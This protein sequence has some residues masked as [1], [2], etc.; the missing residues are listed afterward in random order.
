M[1][2][3]DNDLQDE[4]DLTRN[5]N[6]VVSENCFDRFDHSSMLKRAH[7]IHWLEEVERTKMSRN[8]RRER[9]SHKRRMISY[10]VELRA[11]GDIT[12]NRRAGKG[13]ARNYKLRGIQSEIGNATSA[14]TLEFICGV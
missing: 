9:R 4:N 11:D 10:F 12:P 14:E 1:C 5:G 6:D 7:R 13:S 3:H 2:N 8:V